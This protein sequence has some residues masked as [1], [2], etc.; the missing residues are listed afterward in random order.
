MQAGIL[1]PK[2]NFVGSPIMAL[3]N[4]DLT[5]SFLITAS[6]FP[7]NKTPCGRMHAALPLDFIERK[8]A[9]EKHNHLV[10]EEVFPK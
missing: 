6:A 5:N 8:C 3:R 9:K 7:R 10:L 1:V 4:P 2:N